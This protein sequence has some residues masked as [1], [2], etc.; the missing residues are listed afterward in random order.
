[1]Y[2]YIYI[3]GFVGKYHTF[4]DEHGMLSDPPENDKNCKLRDLMIKL[5][6]KSWNIWFSRENSAKT[7]IFFPGHT[8]SSPRLKQFC[9]YFKRDFVCDGF[10]KFIICVVD[11]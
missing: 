4:S 8:N 10:Y 7:Q 3:K 6:K 1:M 11:K 5:D 2:I 9:R